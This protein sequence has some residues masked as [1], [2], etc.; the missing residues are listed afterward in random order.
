MNT[1][2][3]IQD[4]AGDRLSP[5]FAQRIAQGEATQ[6]QGLFDTVVP[7]YYGWLDYDIEKR[8]QDDRTIHHDISRADHTALTAEQWIRDIRQQLLYFDTITVPDPLADVM[9][10]MAMMVNMFRRAELPDD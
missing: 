7:Y 10:P 6:L 3:L 5:D 4:F 9:W 1:I 8:P 2:E